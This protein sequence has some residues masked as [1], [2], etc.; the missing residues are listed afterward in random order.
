MRRH[1]CPLGVCIIAFGAGVI[2][3]CL[4]PWAAVCFAVALVA[5]AAGIMILC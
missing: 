4:M 3:S 1:R 2:L 5:V